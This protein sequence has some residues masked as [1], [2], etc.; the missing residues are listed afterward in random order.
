VFFKISIQK[1]EAIVIITIIEP[2]TTGKVWFDTV[3]YGD[4]MNQRH[5][6]CRTVKLPIS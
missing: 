4:V 6:I 1:Q 2:E 3:L 5:R